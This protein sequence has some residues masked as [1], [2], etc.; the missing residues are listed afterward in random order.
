[1]CD[2]ARSRG[3]VI[4]FREITAENAEATGGI[5]DSRRGVWLFPGQLQ[6]DLA[7]TKRVVPR[8][9][10]PFAAPTGDTSLRECLQT[11]AVALSEALKKV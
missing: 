2:Y 4:D 1:M 7:L 5:P 9:S 3:T 6:Y 11:M 10:N 8:Q